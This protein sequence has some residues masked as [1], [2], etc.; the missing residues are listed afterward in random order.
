MRPFPLKSVHVVPVPGYD[1][2]FPASSNSAR[3]LVTA[4]TVVVP[5]SQ[6][7]AVAWVTL[8]YAKASVL[9]V[10]ATYGTFPAA[11]VSV[12]TSVRAALYTNEPDVTVAI[13]AGPW[14]T[15]VVVS[16]AVVADPASGAATV[17]VMVV[18]PTDVGVTVKLI[19]P[20][21]GAYAET[22]A[23]R[24]PTV[25]AIFANAKLAVLGPESTKVHVPLATR[26]WSAH[27]PTVTVVGSGYGATVTGPE[28]KRYELDVKPPPG[29]LILA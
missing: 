12:T 6:I 4:V 7:G 23:A 3:P 10:P 27:V 25:T 14:T 21:P 29:A 24:L 17:T 19:V 5:I 13:A 26:V 11:S 2:E 1:A 18:V 8:A 9:V 15:V 20:V 22:V 16:V 28:T